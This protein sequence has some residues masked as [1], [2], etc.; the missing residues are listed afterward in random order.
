[1][2]EW[3][4]FDRD[5]VLVVVLWQVWSRRNGLVHKS[6]SIFEDEVIPWV[7][8]LLIDFQRVNAGGEGEV[9]KGLPVVNS[10]RPPS[11]GLS[12]VNTDAAVDGS[13]G[14]V[15]VGIINRNNACDI[16]GS[17]SQPFNVMM[18]ADMAEA[19]AIFRGLI[20]AMEAGLLPCVVESDAQ[21]VARLINEAYIPLSDMDKDPLL[22][23]LVLSFVE[24]A[25]TWY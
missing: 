1:M 24:F 2:H 4:S 19:P 13:H 10:W 5:G 22:N 12:K 6:A 15:G 11:E 17:S 9:G 20:F 23:R 16:L 25:Y 3:P 8:A 7:E 21:V 18:V 14:K